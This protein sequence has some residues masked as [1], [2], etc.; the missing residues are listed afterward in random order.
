MSVF[1]ISPRISLETMVLR[2]EESV[3]HYFRCDRASAEV[4]ISGDALK[5]SRISGDAHLAIALSDAR[6]ALALPDDVCLIAAHSICT[7]YERQGL[8]MKAEYL[9]AKEKHDLVTKNRV[10]GKG[11][12][13]KQTAEMAARWEP[14]V[15]RYRDLRNSGRARLIARQIVK[16]E[17][18]KASFTTS[19][20]GIFP[21]ESTIRKYLRD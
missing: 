20:T 12:G 14:Y 1:G 17:M 19:P 8:K 7:S 3:G 9:A 10:A 13:V 15:T 4:A 16:K 11:R 5:V 6:A 18:T 2:L 21:S